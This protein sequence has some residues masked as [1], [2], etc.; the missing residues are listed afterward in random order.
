V[1]RIPKLRWMDGDRSEALAGYAY[2]VLAAP[3]DTD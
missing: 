3:L 2:S 1:K